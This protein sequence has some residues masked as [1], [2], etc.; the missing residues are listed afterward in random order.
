PDSPEWTHTPEA[1]RAFE[2]TADY[3]T[4]RGIA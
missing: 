4:A 2:N 1:Q 3:L